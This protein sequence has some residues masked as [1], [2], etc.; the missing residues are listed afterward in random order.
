MET[1]LNGR[2]Y[3]AFD[4]DGHGVLYANATYIQKDE[5]LRLRGSSEF[6]E[7]IVGSPAPESWIRFWLAPQENGT[8]FSIRHDFPQGISDHSVELLSTF[9]RYL[10]EQNLQPYIESGITAHYALEGLG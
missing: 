4:D 10:L 6:I 7:L 9:W 1:S 5:M 3:E 8:L 2:F